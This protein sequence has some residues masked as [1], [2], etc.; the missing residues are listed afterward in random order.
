MSWTQNVKVI[1]KRAG[2]V[3]DKHSL[4]KVSRWVEF[5]LK[6]PIF[7]GLC[8]KSVLLSFLAEVVLAHI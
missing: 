7:S 4:G 6:S 3:K 8:Y 2:L 1:V 5:K